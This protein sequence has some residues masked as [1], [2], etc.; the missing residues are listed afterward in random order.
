MSKNNKSAKSKETV[1]TK[2]AGACKQ[3]MQKTGEKLPAEKQSKIQ[4][5]RPNARSS[6]NSAR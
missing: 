6:T 2:R 1:E 4:N 5:E 3:N